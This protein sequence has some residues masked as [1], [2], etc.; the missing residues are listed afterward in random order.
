MKDISTELDEILENKKIEGDTSKYK[1][2]LKT[3][4]AQLDYKMNMRSWFFGSGKCSGIKGKYELVK[5][6]D[7]VEL[8]KDLEHKE[9]M[10]TTNVYAFLCIKFGKIKQEKDVEQICDY[11]KG[12]QSTDLADGI[13]SITMKNDVVNILKKY[14]L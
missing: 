11:I 5:G 12:S 14:N 3:L 8:Q 6:K 1:H 7:F 10:L 13:V 4:Y 2:S 9:V